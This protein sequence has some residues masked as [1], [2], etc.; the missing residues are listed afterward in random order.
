M[1]V[2]IMDVVPLD[3][4][5][6]ERDDGG[7]EEDPDKELVHFQYDNASVLPLGLLCPAGQLPPAA[8]PQ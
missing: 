2:M 1:T 8:K 4:A 3:S 7:L 5:M 6:D